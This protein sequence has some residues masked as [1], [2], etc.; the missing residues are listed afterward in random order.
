MKKITHYSYI[1]SN[2]FLVKRAASL[3]QF[4]GLTASSQ[5]LF[6]FELEKY[7]KSTKMHFK[8]SQGLYQPLITC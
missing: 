1:T 7:I 5:A 3:Q 4:V 8:A 6:C 2:E